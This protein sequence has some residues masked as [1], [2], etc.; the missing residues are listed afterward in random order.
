MI[1]VQNQIYGDGSLRRW[2]LGRHCRGGWF[3]MRLV[4]ATPDASDV[5]VLFGRNTSAK[6]QHRR[7][8]HVSNVDITDSKQPCL[9]VNPHSV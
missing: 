8:E 6:V 1:P 5:L 9:Y 2:P 3:Q 7:L 4:P